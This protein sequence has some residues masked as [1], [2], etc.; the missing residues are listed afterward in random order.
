MILGLMRSCVLCTL[1]WEKKFVSAPIFIIENISISDE[2]GLMEITMNNLSTE[3]QKTLEG[4]IQDHKAKLPQKFKEM[5][6]QW[7]KLVKVWQ[8]DVF[9]SLLSQIKKLQ[10]QNNNFGFSEMNEALQ[11]L[12]LLVS[13]LSPD[14]FNI[15]QAHQIDAQLELL[16]QE[17]LEAESL[18]HFKKEIE[19]DEVNTF[20]WIIDSDLEFSEKLQLGIVSAGLS[21]QVYFDLEI[22][23]GARKRNPLPEVMILDIHTVQKEKELWEKMVSFCKNNTTLIFTAHSDE[24]HLRLQA[25]RYGSV[26][27]FTKP[28]DF[29][30]LLEKLKKLALKKTSIKFFRILVIDDDPDITLYC[31]DILKIK[32]FDVCR[33]HNPL[34]AIDVIHFFGPDL[35]L[36]DINMPGCNGLE[37]AAMIRQKEE[38]AKTPIVFL[39][40]PENLNKV[41]ETIKL[42][43]DDFLTKPVLAE[44]LLICIRQR[45]KDWDT[46]KKLLQQIEEGKEKQENTFRKLETLQ[47]EQN[48]VEQLQQGEI[49]EGFIL[50]GNN[51]ESYVIGQKLGKG[52][53]GVTYIAV[54]QSDQTKV[55]VKT[56]LP[57]YLNETSVLVRFLQEARTIIKLDHDNLVRG[58]E[59]YQGNRFCYFVMEYVGGYSVEDILQKKT[60]LTP[61]EAATIIFA[62]SRGLYY[63]EQHEIVHRDIKPANII[64]NRNDIAK[65][66]DFGISK[67]KA[68]E[69][70]ITTQGFVMGTP[71]YMS[72]EQVYDN[73]ADVRSD[74]YALGISF[75]YMVTG[76]LP[77]EADN[78]EEALQKRLEGPFDPRE[79]RPQIPLKVSLIIQ[80][81]IQPNVNSRYQ[82]ANEL[83]VDLEAFLAAQ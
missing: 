30:R 18:F 53:M 72:P 24:I 57:R 9:A 68:R 63:L 15:E 28:I 47:Q 25:V 35:I 2:S 55:V 76:L 32:G 12:E 82:S 31:S 51:G 22:L 17:S 49:T 38:I 26:A 62:I 36:L 61:A 45:V 10:G 77:F 65:L 39:S 70:S 66:V 20:V 8:Y 58:Y 21:C 33:L 73:I 81:M 1:K 52:G 46:E 27:Y 13:P 59:L 6:K 41:H 71:D 16:Y 4:L 43:V 19:V 48:S 80:K 54:R 67:P 56:L 64:I 50:P 42:D 44:Q 83:I 34:E 14:S 60:F 5:E 11:K 40:T 29:P 69:K 78:T 74:I 79:K 23:R 7:Q 37:L 3:H 75:F